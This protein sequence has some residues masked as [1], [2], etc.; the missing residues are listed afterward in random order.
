MEDFYIDGKRV[1][2]VG[3]RDYNRLDE[4]DEFV[5]SLPSDCVIV[6][7]GARGVDSAAVI[8]AKK[9]GLKYKVWEADWNR[10]GKQA[11]FIRN[12]QIVHDSDCVVAFWDKTSR[13]TKHT[14]DYARDRGIRVFLFG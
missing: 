11:G 5:G 1:A 3:S 13:G 10:Y 14:I 6:S 8:A 12:Y 7:G 2:V 9:Y 4:V